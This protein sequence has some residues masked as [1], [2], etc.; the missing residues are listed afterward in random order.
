M[1]AA[2][3]P[4]ERCIKG[5]G[6]A[7]MYEIDSGLELLPDGK[8]PDGSKP[9]VAVLS[10]EEFAVY[11]KL[12]DEATR[13]QIAYLLTAESCYVEVFHDGIIG[14]IAAPNKQDLMG[15]RCLYSFYW[16]RELLVFID[17]SGIAAA[18]MR[19]VADSEK[20]EGLTTARCLHDFFRELIEGEPTWLGELEDAMEDTESRMLDDPQRTT[21]EDINRFRHI[22]IRITSYYQQMASMVLQ[23][24]ANDN[25]LMTP[26]EA[27]AFEPIV[28]FMDRLVG[29]AE[30]VREY[31][32]Q[33]R[34]LH[35]TQL[36]I[37]QNSTMQLL[38][39]VTVLL[40]PLTLIAGWFGMNF[41]YIPGIAEPW[42]FA[43]ICVVGVL[44]TGALVLL[45][46]RKG[47]L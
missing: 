38:T 9:V 33:L 10:D 15:D 25:D 30:M 13:R 1:C 3:R 27:R 35:Q 16:E 44:I 17:G 24:S 41:A 19:R 31:G 39:I 46:H 22:S 18:T 34:E 43:V 20:K 45:F 42:G 6:M 23:I 28:S 7:L 29:R 5:D 14:S 8:L 4:P 2:G 37:K 40:A 47:W 12:V 21:T 36:D 11:G 32:L 26:E